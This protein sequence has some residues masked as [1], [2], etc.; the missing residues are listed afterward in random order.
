MSPAPVTGE[1]P[2][3]VA[4][5]LGIVGKSAVVTVHGLRLERQP[6][7]EHFRIAFEA[8]GQA[9]VDCFAQVAGAQATVAGQLL[10]VLNLIGEGAD[11]GLAVTE[12]A[13][14]HLGLFPGAG[15]QECLDVVGE[16][17][18]AG[19]ADQLIALVRLI[20]V[21]AD[22]QGNHAEQAKAGEQNDFQADRERVEHGR[23]R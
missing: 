7:A 3:F 17:G 2:A 11:D 6:D 23:T 21:D 22:D 9:L 19:F 4:Q 5:V 10:Q 18:G 15:L 20:Q 1:T 12:G 14:Q 13:P 8:G 16:H